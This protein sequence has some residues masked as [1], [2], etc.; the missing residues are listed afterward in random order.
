[1]SMNDMFHCN[2]WCA[3]NPSFSDLHVHHHPWSTR[4]RDLQCW[5]HCLEAFISSS[6][7]NFSVRHCVHCKPM[8]SHHSRPCIPRTSSMPMNFHQGGRWCSDI[9][10]CSQRMCSSL[11]SYLFDL[12]QIR[13]LISFPPSSLKSHRD[14][15]TLILVSVVTGFP[16]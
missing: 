5:W 4:K 8:L 11:S 3:C 10:L 6:L 1:M 13:V 15:T 12:D 16:L 9:P 14:G 7:H 2:G